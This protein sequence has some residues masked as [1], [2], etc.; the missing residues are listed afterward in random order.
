MATEGDN[1]INNYIKSNL[2]IYMN[3]DFQERNYI[4]KVNSK[5]SKK[6]LAKDRT[7]KTTDLKLVADIS[8]EYQ[9]E[10]TSDDQVKK[11]VSFY[12]DFNIK[13]NQ[14][15]FQQRDYEKSIKKNL[16]QK[17]TDKIIRHLTLNK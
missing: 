3:K 14:N 12:E 4:I 11:V 6:S 5:F 9:E 7:G 8:L 10:S 2:A 13:K 16:S 1:Q 15:N 17:L